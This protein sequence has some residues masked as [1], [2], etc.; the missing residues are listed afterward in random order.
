MAF[1][2]WLRRLLRGPAPRVDQFTRDLF[3]VHGIDATMVGQWIVFADRDIRVQAEIVQ[4][5]PDASGI[6][7]QLDVRI[8]IETGQTIIESFGGIGKTKGRAVASALENF[9]VNSFHVIIAAF[10]D[11]ASDQVSQEQWIIGGTK[12]LVTLGNIGIKG[13][14][15]VQPEFLSSWFKHF[16]EILRVSE[17]APGTHWVRFYYAQLDGKSMA[18]EVLLDNQVQFEMQSQMSTVDWPSDDEFYSVRMFLVVQ[19]FREN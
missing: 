19:D 13:R 7:V 4:E 14:P 6:T 3:R 10:F 11:W 12:R 1:G 5:L 18:C 8:E 2:D 9:T 15:P 17:L 16:E